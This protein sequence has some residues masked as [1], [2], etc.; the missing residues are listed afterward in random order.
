MRKATLLN[1]PIAGVI[2]RMGHM[3]SLCLGDAG[4]PIPDH[5]DRIDLAVAAGLPG[6]LDVLPVLTGELFVERAVIAEEL[7]ERQPQ[8]HANV[9]AH[10]A[11]L[12]AEQGNDIALDAV[13]HE[14]FKAMTG[15]CKAVVRTGEFTPYA[16]IILVSGVPF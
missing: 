14:A 7:A 12:G 3:D 13:P 2:A 1:A 15:A 6:F 11:A 4:L 8:F 5:V 16:N 10:L 9:L